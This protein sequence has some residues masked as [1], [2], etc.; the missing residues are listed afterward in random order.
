MN[1]IEKKL[2]E[3]KVKNFHFGMNVA[4]RQRIF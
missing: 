2:L 1:G 4:L 3:K